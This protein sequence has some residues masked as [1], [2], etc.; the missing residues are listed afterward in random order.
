MNPIH[1]FLLVMLL[2]II[3]TSALSAYK[4]ETYEEQQIYPDT[5]NDLT[6]Y[7]FLMK[8]KKWDVN[9]LSPDLLYILFTMRAL[10][11]K[12]YIH[13]NRTFPYVN[14]IVIP[15]EHMP[16]FNRDSN[17][18]SD[19]VITTPNKQFVLKPTTADLYPQGIQIEL[20][21]LT[22]GEFR[23]ILNVLSDMYNSEFND[24]VKK[25][26]DRKKL[27]EAQIAPLDM[28][29]Q[30]LSTEVKMLTKQL[31]DK[32][33]ECEPI[34]ANVKNLKSEIQKHIACSS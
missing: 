30:Q 25:L 16:V 15:Y 33:A 6:A 29:L 14:A 8:H 20:S 26:K 31:K 11:V 17:D 9:S 1:T 12:Q 2:I 13:N 10:Q 32:Q 22:F 24:E 5:P 3:M 18:K 27:V 34:F 4:I 28:Q 7:N 19:F 23:G 21:E